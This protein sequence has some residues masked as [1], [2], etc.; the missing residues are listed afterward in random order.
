MLRDKWHSRSL[1]FKISSLYILA[2]LFVFMVNMVLLIGINRMSNELEKVYQENL[3]LNVLSESLNG[4]QDSMTE[5]LSSKTSE[6]LENF[7]R[8]EQAYNAMIMELTDDVSSV[9]FER[10]ERNIKSMSEQYLVMAN[11]TI[12]STRGRNVEKY[13][14]RYE[15]ASQ[16]YEYI[17]SYI[18]GLNIEQFAANSENYNELTHVFG[19]FE[20]LS[21]VV[22]AVLMA[23]NVMII[24]KFTKSMFQ[25]LMELSDLAN[26]V[27]KGNLD[28]DLLEKRSDDE[29]GV[30]TNAFNQMIV[31]IRQYIEQTK[32]SIE[33]ERLLKEKELKM[34]AQVKDAKLKYLQAQINPHFLFNTLNA[35]AQL[36]MMEG[37]DTTYDYV[38]RVA[39]FFRYNV[40]KG[41][42]IVT[43]RD[44]IALNDNY[45]YILNVRFSGEIHYEKQIEEE[46]LDI[47]MPS[48]ILQPIVENCVNH[49]IREMEGEGKIWV[50]VYEMDGKIFVS[51]ADNGKGMS[52]EKIEKI[53]NGTYQA[54]HQ[55]SDSNGIALDNVIARLQLFTG[56][57]QVIEIVSAGEGQGT[58]FII[59]LGEKNHL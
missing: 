39:D 52:P 53:L 40:K 47:P 30:V 4:V 34:E 41:N 17:N 13:R 18:Y 26:E 22:M 35:G 38:Q 44:E 32:A 21:M 3:T 11:Q 16:L 28:V 25:P 36:A 58:E 23:T 14:V 59:C 5:Y 29:I 48:M 31:S 9:S 19:I 45:I 10:M 37:A 50:S 2:N 27:A 33:M 49:G 57:E 8:N 51:V 12:E 46:W 6:S 24:V 43:I 42:D 55:R 1:Q 7:Y 15:N 54:E 56:C 20:Y